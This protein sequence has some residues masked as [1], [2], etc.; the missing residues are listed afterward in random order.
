M[1]L[2]AIDTWC[3]R[4]LRALPEPDAAT[5]NPPPARS[6]T[7]HDTH[8]QHPSSNR[9]GHAKDTGAPAARPREDRSQQARGARRE[10][11]PP[12]APSPPPSPM[13]AAPVTGPH[14]K[15]VRFKS[16]SVSSKG[17][18]KATHDASNPTDVHSELE[19]A[20][21]G[22]IIYTKD[23]WLASKRVAAPSTG[24]TTPHTTRTGQPHTTQGNR[25]HHQHHQQQQGAQRASDHAGY[26]SD[27]SGGS[28][29]ENDTSPPRKRVKPGRPS[30]NS[31]RGQAR[32]D[33]RTGPTHAAHG[34]PKGGPARGGGIS[35]LLGRASG[36]RL[37]AATT[38]QEAS[39]GGAHGVG[40]EGHYPSSEW[41]SDIR[42]EAREVREIR[43][44]RKRDHR[45]GNGAGHI[46]RKR[47]HTGAHQGGTG[48]KEDHMGGNA[49]QGQELDA[50]QG[51]ADAEYSDGDREG[52]SE[53][54]HVSDSEGGVSDDDRYEGVKLAGSDRDYSPDGEE[55]VRVGGEEPAEPQRVSL[56]VCVPPCKHFMQSVMSHAQAPQRVSARIHGCTPAASIPNN[57]KHI[58]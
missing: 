55:D 23:E 16:P 42:E 33:A 47:A 17:T 8:T 43:E 31:M 22:Y 44:G 49:E 6:D 3:K 38:A 30:G 13:D 50:H 58:G 12:R 34:V 54:E 18:S 45:G 11:A 2:Q 10:T 5:M 15:V 19:A 40:S 20:G 1:Q 41:P 29:S 7:P 56:S 39:V 25:Q 53:G 28:D 27:G 46:S 9:H 4:V 36:F 51:G 52:V 14:R 32:P 24:P 57:W 48:D 21:L 37:G 35:R 26:V